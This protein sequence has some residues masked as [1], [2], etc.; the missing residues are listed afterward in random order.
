VVARAD[1]LAVEASRHSGEE[2]RRLLVEAAE[3]RERLFPHRA[4]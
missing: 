3:L 2:A 1:A 4:S